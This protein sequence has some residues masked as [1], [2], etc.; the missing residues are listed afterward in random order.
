[1][2]RKVAG[3]TAAAAGRAP[4]WATAGG[5]AG[6]ALR[7]M[8]AA[9]TAL[10][11]AVMLRRSFGYVRRA[12]VRDKGYLRSARNTRAAVTRARASYQRNLQ[13]GAAAYGRDAGTG[14]RAASG[15]AISHAG[16]LRA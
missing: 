2:G 5:A 6:A 12:L 3:A 9:V 15:A 4:A 11:A 10:P 13:E 8:A 14:R 1:M 16:C 7:V